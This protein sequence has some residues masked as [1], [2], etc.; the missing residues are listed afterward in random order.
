MT[1]SCANVIFLATLVALATSISA[2]EYTVGDASGWTLDFDYQTWT[3][4]KQFFV[5]DK[6]VFNYSPGKHNVLKVNGTSFQQCIMPS[7]NEAL[8]SGNDV[9]TLLTPGRKWYVCGIGKH[10]ELRNMKLVINVESMSPA[11]SPST[12]SGSST[13]VIPKTYGFA[14]AFIGSLLMFLI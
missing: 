10:C 12:T 14:A 4:G 11:P 7:S 6:L 13:L 8:T 3:Q 2:T 9:V 5:G 1:M